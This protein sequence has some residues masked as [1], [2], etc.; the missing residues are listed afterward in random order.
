MARSDAGSEYLR[1]SIHIGAGA[2]AFLLPYL[3]RSQ[4][5]AF[6]FF[7][8]VFN[9][10][11]LPRIAGGIL[12]RKEEGNRP[13]GIY[14][15]PFSLLVLF[16]LFSHELAI[17]AAMWGILAFGDGFASVAGV[18]WGKRPLPWNEEKSW[19]GTGA[20]LLLGGVGSSLFF[21]WVE[22][23]HPSTSTLLALLLTL[24][25]CAIIESL[26]SGINDNL[27]VPFLGGLLLYTLL[28]IDWSSFLVL[29]PILADRLPIA[30][31]VNV[32]CAILAYAAGTVSISGLFFGLV[33]G[34]GIYLFAG[35]P[36]FLLL[37]IFFVLGSA[38]TR[39]GYRR[40]L[41]RGLAQAH[42]GRRRASH[43]IA[44]GGVPF[45]L[46]IAAFAAPSSLAPVFQAAF[47]ASLA[48]AAFDTVASEVGKYVGGPTVSLVS[49]R[50]SQAGER[51]GMSLFGT[52]S[53]AIAALSLSLA[54]WG[55]QLIEA[56]LIPVLLL[57][58]F[59]GTLLESFL[60][61]F[62]SR[63]GEVSGE[64]LNLFNTAL[65]G[66]FGFLFSYPMLGPS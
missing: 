17:A 56:P 59:L 60:G 54:A 39:I 7:G 35:L 29:A 14:L 30:L 37:L 61:G 47:I 23:F 2:L 50:V 48:T 1:Q 49:T 19:A 41:R 53:G 65:G 45:L 31:G 9:I 8:L 20:F 40:K 28:R 11:L 52:G 3:T 21:F 16:V 15:Y 42:G 5:F 63:K 57:A 13:L 43:T 51:G 24:L 33:I 18:L 25:I 10:F 4:I 6:T 62:F 34:M 32:L 46:S 22:G 27:S 26:P 58:A 64:F 38:S 44:N 12:V 66:L 36:G 55:L